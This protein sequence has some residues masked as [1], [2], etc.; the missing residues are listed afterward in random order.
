MGIEL[1]AII[2]AYFEADRRGDA[3]RLAL[4]FTAKAVVTDEGRTHAG[5]TAIRQW[6][7]G[8]SRTYSYSADP[9]SIANDRSWTVVTSS[10]TGNFPG[11]PINLAYAF[12]LEDDAIAALEITS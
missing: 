10:V 2:A 12:R 1:P 4:F 5:R 11:S 7:A 3:E 9:R 8:A 6:K